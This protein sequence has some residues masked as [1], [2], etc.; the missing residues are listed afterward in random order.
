MTRIKTER[1]ERE[2]KKRGWSERRETKGKRERDRR[3]K[4]KRNRRGEGEMTEETEAF[5]LP[6]LQST[7][8]ITPTFTNYFHYDFITFKCS[9]QHHLARIDT[10]NRE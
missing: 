8:H 1:G 9:Q 2:E 10:T 7:T 4:G 5:L 6:L 3:G